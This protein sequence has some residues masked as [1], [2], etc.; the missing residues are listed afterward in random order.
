LMD[1]V[2]SNQRFILRPAPPFQLAL[3]DMLLPG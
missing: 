1:P 3:H 2:T